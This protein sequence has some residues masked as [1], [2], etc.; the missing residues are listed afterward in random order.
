MH[1]YKFGRRRALTDYFAHQALG[2]LA[3]H[4]SGE[5]FDGVVAVPSDEGRDRRRGY[6]P[7]ALVA[8]AIARGIGSPY[9]ERSLVRLDGGRPQSLLGRAE[10]L[11]GAVRRFAAAP[12]ARLKDGRLLLVDDILTTGQTVSDCAR[13][14]KDAGAAGV[15]VLALTRGVLRS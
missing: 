4:A 11:S 12:R 2:T 7:A 8:A 13:A 14:L 15:V 1:A 3:R 9:L 6:A 5:T 10:R